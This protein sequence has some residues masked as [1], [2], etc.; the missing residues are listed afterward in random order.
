M[1]S[2]EKTNSPVIEDYE[3]RYREFDYPFFAILEGNGYKEGI[4]A[5]LKSGGKTFGTLWLNSLEKNYFSP[6]QFEI[7]QTL[8]D[9]VAVAVANILANEEIIRREQEKT[10]LLSISREIAKVQTREQLL[11]VIFNTVKS[12]FPYD[13]AGLFYFCD[14]S[15]APNQQ[16]EWTSTCSTT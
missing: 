4:A 1:R 16:G 15:G 14:R 11:G 10:K 3:A 7:F 9:Q 13:H 2:I 12:I 5:A 6:Q 8:A